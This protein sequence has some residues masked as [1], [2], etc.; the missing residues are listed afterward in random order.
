[1]KDGHLLTAGLERNISFLSRT[2][3]HKTPF[4]PPTTTTT[5]TGGTTNSNTVI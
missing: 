1:M 3:L 2:A 5:W 4:L